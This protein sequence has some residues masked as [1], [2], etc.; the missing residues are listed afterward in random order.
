MDIVWFSLK[1]W[2]VSRRQAIDG[3]NVMVCLRVDQPCLDRSKIEN[4]IESIK[5][6][7]LF[8][9]SSVG[10]DDLVHAEASP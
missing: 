5:K 2:L 8:C 3:D 10:G 6:L 4:L 9:E 1:G 7:D